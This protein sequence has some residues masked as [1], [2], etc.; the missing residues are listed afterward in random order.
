MRRPNILLIY[1]DQL[2]WDALPANGN[3]DV[4]T[5]HLDKLMGESV[6]FSHCFVQHPLCMPSRVSF[7]SGRYPSTLGITRMGVPVPETLP[8]LPSYLKP[9]GYTTASIGKLHFL[10][11]A[12]RDHRV[13]HPSYGFNHLEVSDE[14]GVYEDAYRAWVRRKDPAQ[15]KHLSVG[16][17]PATHQWYNIMGTQDT[18]EHPKNEARWDIGGAIPFPGDAAYTYSAFVA[19]QSLEFLRRQSQNNPFLCI[20]SFYSPHSP[21]VAP[22]SYIDLYDPATLQIPTFPKNLEPHRKEAH[23]LDAD[24]R[25]ARQGYYAMISEV[26]TYVGQLLGTL[27]ER[28][29]RDSTMIVFT[30]DHGD[31]LG[32]HLKYGKGYPGDDAVSR[33]PLVVWYEGIKAKIVSHV[34]EAVDVVPTLLE[35]AGIQQPPALQGESLVPLLETSAIEQH[36]KVREKGRKKDSALMEFQ[37]WKTLRTNQYRYLVHTDGSEGLWDVERDPQEYNDVAKSKNYQSVLQDHRRLL[38]ARLLEAERPLER[39]WL[40]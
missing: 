8:I 16:L 6:N 1:T 9:Y 3:P 15:L 13:P 40:Y 7:L 36:K 30:S 33:V 10:P 22:Q 2:R 12:N 31:W 38:L 17:P 34:V 39:T 11:H 37:G 25:A 21:W 27:E 5:P 20:A 28:G 19:E 35:L 26:D 18:V 24:L 14:P 29:L 23:A 32:E 4:K